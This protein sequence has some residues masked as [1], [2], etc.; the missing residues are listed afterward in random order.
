LVR[1][2]VRGIVADDGSP[3]TVNVRLILDAKDHNNLSSF[4]AMEV[5]I[6]VLADVV[7]V[8]DVFFLT[9]GIYFGGSIIRMGL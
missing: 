5:A 2:V 6:S 3:F 1:E 8:N 9:H 7:E 4:G